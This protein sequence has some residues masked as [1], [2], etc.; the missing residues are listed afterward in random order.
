MDTTFISI[1]DLSE[2]AH[3]LYSSDSIVDILG[4]TPD[5]V[6]DKSVWQFFHPDE[7][8]FAKQ[9]HSRSVKLDK[10][11][12]LSYCRIKN[13]Q[14]DWVGCECCFSIVYDV[15]VCCTS[16]YRQG[17]NSQKRAQEAPIVRKLFSSSP[18]DPRYHMLSY[19]SS[20]FTLGPEEQTHEP[21]AALFLNRFTRTLT[22][23]HAT[24]G[25]EEILGIPSDDM[26]GRSFY[27]CIA[28]ECLTDAVK[29]LESAKGNDSIA[30]LRFFFRDPRQ[31]DPPDPF[32]S[33]SEDEVMTDITSS[34]DESETA[35]T[36]GE[37][38]LS[39]NESLHSRSHRS[40]ADVSASEENSS[41]NTNGSHGHSEA[42]SEV[43]SLAAR[44]PFSEARD[45]P[46]ELEAVVSCTSDG[47]VVCLR[48]AR[49]EQ[50]RPAPRP[51]G[52]N[53]VYAAPWA[54]QP[55]FQPALPQLPP[56]P[57]G[58]AHPAMAQ[59]CLPSAAQSSF[60]QAIRDVAVFAWALVGINGSLAEYANP[61]SKPVGEAQPPDGFPIWGPVPGPG[62]R[63]KSSV[64]RSGYGSGSGSSSSNDPFGFGDPGLK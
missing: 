60:M 30:Y 3:I 59:L 42:R 50:P 49:P 12:V 5:E 39:R 47:L 45:E 38:S 18:K 31:D 41:N 21:R 58:G 20:K 16:I 11:S 1:H 55:M 8:P 4:H 26:K 28:E 46:I 27:F 36:E 61:L 51:V 63:D 43:S 37:H 22:V 52:Y 13:R 2:D 7:L 48:R 25:I 54:H 14:G 57:L 53:G 19:L 56:Y 32:T 6:V 15:M 29:C 23:M 35:T 62:H 44:S 24:R 34:E 40:N 64:A 9:L 10:A 33:E 17:M